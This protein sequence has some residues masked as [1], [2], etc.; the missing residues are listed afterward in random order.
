MTIKEKKLFDKVK[1]YS[2][3]YQINLQMW[4]NWT[5]I[6]VEKDHVDLYSYGGSLPLDKVLDNIIEYLDRINKKTK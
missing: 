4:P 6:F 1:N 5:C 2:K 3:K